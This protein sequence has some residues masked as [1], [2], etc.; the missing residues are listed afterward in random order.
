MI[1]FSL[2]SIATNYPKPVLNENDD[3]KVVIALPHSYGNI[4]PNITITIRYGNG[5]IINDT[6]PRDN[7]NI[8]GKDIVFPLRDNISGMLSVAYRMSFFGET[9]TLSEFSNQ[10]GQCYID[11][12]TLL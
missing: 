7:I 4:K 5:H 1:L 2:V 3:W 11:T 6:I 12:G 9:S 8:D 10:T